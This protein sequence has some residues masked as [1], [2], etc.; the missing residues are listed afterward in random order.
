[1]RAYNCRFEQKTGITGEPF[2]AE[3][4][5]ILVLDQA[6]VSNTKVPSGQALYIAEAAGEG[7]PAGSITTMSTAADTTSPVIQTATDFAINEN[8]TAG[9]IITANEPAQLRIL[10]G[11]NRDKF[12][13]Y[14]W[15]LNIFRQD[16]EKLASP[17]VSCDIVM[18]DLKRNPS[19][20]RTVNVTIN[21][22]ADD[23]IAANDLFNKGTYTET[24]AYR[25]PATAGAWLTIEPGFI[26]Q[27]YEMTI[28]AI[29]PGGSDCRDH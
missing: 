20:V 28:P 26:W 15:R 25:P 13:T 16:Y 23:P 7:N 18:Y 17:T 29:N 19:A 9:W 22:V 10:P 2:R 3:Q 11:K 12:S 6:T 27:D 14:G 4:G 24:G 1:M 5:G 8:V 21:N